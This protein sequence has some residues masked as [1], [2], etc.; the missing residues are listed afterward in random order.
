MELYNK[1]ISKYKTFTAYSDTLEIRDTKK[2]IISL[3]KEEDILIRGEFMI[4]GSYSSQKNIWIWGDQS[5]VLDKTMIEN[6]KNIRLK[7]L[8]DNLPKN[9]RVFVDNNYDV[10]PTSVLMDHL[11]VISRLIKGSIVVTQSQDIRDIV[12]IKNIIH[13][14]M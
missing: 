11:E 5:M 8:S 4:L 10:M 9:T 14:N 1:L 6:I 3:Y 12:L 7:I 2:Y 13:D